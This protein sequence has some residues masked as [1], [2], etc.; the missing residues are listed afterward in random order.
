MSIPP[1]RSALVR[2]ARPGRIAQLVEHL[3]HN[4][5]VTGSSP[6]PPT[7]LVNPVRM[8]M[9]HAS[10]PSPAPT[11]TPTGGRA[12]AFRRAPRPGLEAA[13]GAHTRHAGMSFA[14]S[15]RFISGI[16]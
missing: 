3:D 15:P 7:T 10:H 12:R 6:V 16:R 13:A 14:T 11:R 9:S 1:D 5:G 4:Q 8:P 2:R